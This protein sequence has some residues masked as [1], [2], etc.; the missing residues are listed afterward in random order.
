MMWKSQECQQIMH[1]NNF[2]I[3]R[4]LMIKNYILLKYWGK[5]DI[6][7]HLLNISLNNMKFKFDK[8]LNVSA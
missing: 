4:V 6:K 2:I 8:W 1:F 5:D 3:K 7:C